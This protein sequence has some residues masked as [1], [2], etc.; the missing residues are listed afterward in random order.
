[1]GFVNH[2]DFDVYAVSLTFEENEGDFAF[3]SEAG[4]ADIGGLIGAIEKP[5]AIQLAMYSNTIRADTKAEKKFDTS[6]GG[7]IGRMHNVP[8]YELKTKDNSVTMT[9]DV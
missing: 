2:T 5:T 6:V 7:L 9:Q 3:I 4:D 1:M 8:R